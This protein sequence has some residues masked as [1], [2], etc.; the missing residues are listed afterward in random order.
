MSRQQ[1]AF[2]CPIIF[3][4]VILILALVKIEDATF[5]LFISGLNLLL[6]AYYFYHLRKVEKDSGQQYEILKE[7][8]NKQFVQLESE[9]KLLRLIRETIAEKNIDVDG[10]VSKLLEGVTEFLGL[11]MG[12]VGDVSDEGCRILYS[13]CNQYKFNGSV[14]SFEKESF[15]KNLTQRLVTKEENSLQV[16]NFSG[17]RISIF[18]FLGTKLS[19][20]GYVICFA[21]NKKRER[22]FSERECA[23]FKL[24]AE[25]ITQELMKQES[26]T[27]LTSAQENLANIIDHLQNSNENLEHFAYVASHDL[28]EPLRMILNFSD[29]LERSCKSVLDEKSKRFLFFI[30]NGAEQMK[31][32]IADLLDYSR[33]QNKIEQFEDVNISQ[34]VNDLKLNLQQML[35]E[36]EAIITMDEL[37]TIRANTIRISRLLQNLIANSIKYR[38]TDESPKIHI[39]F[40]DTREAWVFFVQD[41][42][43]G[44]SAEYHA[45]IFEPFKRLHARSE[46]GGTGIGL[47]ICKKI[48]ALH[49]GKIWIES[50]IGEGSSVY[51]SIPKNC[52]L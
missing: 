12:F 17:V 47:A 48:I 8:E 29:L 6:A 27:E 5:L 19:R 9:Q 37:P 32:L 13:F 14:V 50:A 43:I 16:L 46:Y 40:Q 2:I 42:G 7:K 20:E 38:K 51:F 18:S 4:V 39:G 33:M 44:I 23:F 30:H 15:L 25:L 21:S 26:I 31:E 52:D 28:Q 34:V 10:K 45:Q 41:N 1:Q 36:E 3:S 49:G 24:V 22:V 11:D 35:I